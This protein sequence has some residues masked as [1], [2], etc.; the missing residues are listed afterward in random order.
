MPYLAARVPSHW[1]VSHVDEEAEDI[2]WTDQPDV[3]GITFHTPS[4]YHAYGLAARF[5]SRGACV[6]MGGPHVTLLPEEA[7]QHADVI[8]VGEAEGHWEEFLDGFVT[9]TYRRV[10]RQD[11]PP[12]LQD[13]P[14][15]RKTLFHRNDFTSGVLFATRGCPNQCDFCAVV[16][17]Y[18]RGLRKRPIAEV[19]AEYGSFHGKRII[20]W[21]DNIAGDKEY[22][23]ELFR[24]IAPYRKWWSSQAS[25]QAARDDEFLDAAARSGCKQLFLGLESLSQSSMEEVHK[26]FNRVEDYARIVNRV[27]AHG[28]AVQAGIV[29][30]F[31]HDTPAIF[32]ETLDFL[33]EAGVQNA[34]F[35]I[36]TPY[37]GTPLFQRLDAQGRILTRDWRKFNG[38]THVVFQPSQ[39]SAD[40]LLAGFRYA[41]QRFYSLPSVAKRLWRSPVQIWWTLPLNLAYVASWANG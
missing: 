4:A 6:V 25:V 35:N 26:G 31:D 21:D 10:Y 29:F 24:A 28:I 20:F 34:T 2:D 18:G 3:V 14:M 8:F 36:L 40:E 38:R 41:N 33:E 5:K 27:H 9:G 37:P 19:A 1:H 12:S 32:K 7:A 11:G 17:M 16:V 39:M 13:V 30:G 22:A 23:K 15:A